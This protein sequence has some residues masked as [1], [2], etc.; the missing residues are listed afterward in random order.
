MLQE[1]VSAQ[2]G[3]QGYIVGEAY[4]V[5]IGTLLRFLSYLPFPNILVI[6]YLYCAGSAVPVHGS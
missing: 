1:Q 6:T 2:C 5:R 3:T 4:C